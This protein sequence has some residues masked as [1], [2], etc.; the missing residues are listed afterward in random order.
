MIDAGTTVFDLYSTIFDALGPRRTSNTAV[1]K[2]IRTDHKT[3]L[4][5]NA[6]W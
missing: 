2:L 6:R 4:S 5:N 3:Y 1:R